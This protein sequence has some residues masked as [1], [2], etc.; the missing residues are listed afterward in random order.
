MRR[1]TLTLALALTVA[2]LAVRP[3]AARSDGPSPLTAA[4]RAIRELRY[5]DARAQLDRAIKRGHHSRRE[6]I[7]LYALRGEAAAIVDGPSVGE[8]EFRRLLVLAP[9]H[10]PPRNTPVF[11]VPFAQ[12]QR[13]VAA[14]GRLQV[15]HQPPDAARPNAPTPIAVA[16]VSDPFAMVA[17]ARLL[18]RL[19]A[20]EPWAQV[21]GLSLQTWLPPVAA[22]GTIAYYIE[23]VDAADDVLA[24]LG[25]ADEP[26]SLEASSESPPP[27]AALPSPKARLAAVAP[28]ASVA[29]AA[30]GPQSIVASDTPAP[31]GHARPQ[32]VAGGVIAGLGLGALA[33]AIGVDVTGR[34]QYDALASSCAPSCSQSAVDGLRLRENAAIGLYASAGA[35]ITTSVILLCVDHFRSR[36][37]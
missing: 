18:Y 21:A 35:A 9:D 37:K 10:A 34:Q 23:V 32:Q 6:L 16:V 29:R 31:R 7:A 22:G 15:E 30:L 27:P 1:R 19:G 5:E 3:A 17:G 8:S 36:A 20:D 24:Q 26:L 28:P 25:S 2:C 13:W 4:Q 12:A 11:S 14:H 33:A